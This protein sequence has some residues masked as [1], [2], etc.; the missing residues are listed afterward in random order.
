[1]AAGAGTISPASGDVS[2]TSFPH[3]PTSFP[4]RREPPRPMSDDVFMGTPWPPQGTGCIRRMV[5]GGRVQ[6]PAYAGMTGQGAGN[7]GRR[8][9]DIRRGNDGTGGRE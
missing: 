1:M 7:D 4:R 8:G 2:T 9:N 6:I 5:C 3:T